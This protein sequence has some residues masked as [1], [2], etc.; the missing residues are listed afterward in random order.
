VPSV[1]ERSLLPTAGAFNVTS[2][3][4]L[5]GNGPPVQMM[6][7]AIGQRLRRGT[8]SVALP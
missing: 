6:I 4:T 5:T 7:V 8:T 2:M 1:A 3:I